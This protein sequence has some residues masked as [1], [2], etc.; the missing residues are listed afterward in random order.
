MWYLYL[1]NGLSASWCLWVAEKPF[2]LP[3]KE[4][5]YLYDRGNPQPLSY[6]SFMATT[7]GNS[8]NASGSGLIANA[9]NSK[10]KSWVD[11]GEEFS[12]NL[13]EENAFRSDDGPQFFV[14]KE[15]KVTF[16]KRHLF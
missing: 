11:H 7:L 8:N 2:A 6:L 14:I 10:L 5:G 3:N 1:F 9:V 16:Q 15:M 13:N 4:M 12:T